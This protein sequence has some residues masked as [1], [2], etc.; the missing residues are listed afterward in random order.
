[1]AK[2]AVPAGTL[3]HV[4]TIRERVE[5]DAAD[6][7]IDRSEVDETENPWRVAIMPLRGRE[8]FDAQQAKSVATHKIIGR[9]YAGLTT[10]HFLMLDTRRFEIE[11]IM[12]I[13]ERHVRHELLCKEIT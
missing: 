2:I 10:N 5:S 7:T 12:D 11:Q 3:R 8:L 13:E 9:Y 6:G 1:M 4:V